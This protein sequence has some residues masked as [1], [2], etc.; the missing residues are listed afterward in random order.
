MWFN[1]H[2]EPTDFIS[3]PTLNEFRLVHSL[4]FACTHECI[5]W[6]WWGWKETLFEHWLLIETLRLD[7]M[8]KMTPL[9]HFFHHPIY[10]L[11][12]KWGYVV[13][14]PNF[15]VFHILFIIY[16][17]FT[18][19]FHLKNALSF[20]IWKLKTYSLTV[21]L[22]ILPDLDEYCTVYCLSFCFV[23]LKDIYSTI[24]MIE[25]LPS[26]VNQELTGLGTDS[27]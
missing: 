3:Y 7:V 18:K 23:N 16:F 22:R 11:N 14:L 2:W 6:D 8:L 19:H 9:V 10:K 24:I 12:T 17:Y 20:E 26:L 15:N 27:T 5:R 4:Q 1:K 21:W 25:I 13:S